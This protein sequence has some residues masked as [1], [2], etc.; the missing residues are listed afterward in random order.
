MDVTSTVE[1]A[2]DH[3][4][5]TEWANLE[6][7]YGGGCSERVKRRDASILAFRPFG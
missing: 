4:E 1:F 2:L 5:L 3:S 6:L 7:R